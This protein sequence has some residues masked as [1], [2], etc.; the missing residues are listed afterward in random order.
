MFSSTW[1]F[2]PFFFL[3]G[4]FKVWFCRLGLNSSPS[5]IFPFVANFSS[6]E[7]LFVTNQGRLWA[8]RLCFCSVFFFSFPLSF[9]CFVWVSEFRVSLVLNYILSFASQLKFG[10]SRVTYLLFL[11]L[12][13]RREFLKVRFWHAVSFWTPLCQ[14]LLLSFRFPC[15]DT[16]GR[17]ILLHHPFWIAEV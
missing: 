16:D 11:P 13:L 3:V 10:N 14:L 15:F 6:L 12:I 2:F 1:E 8:L 5:S 4:C 7:S 9:F 17:E